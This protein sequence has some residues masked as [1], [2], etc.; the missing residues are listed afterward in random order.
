MA[1]YPRLL[2]LDYRALE[3]TAEGLENVAVLL[4]AG[5]PKAPAA[6]TPKGKWIN[7]KDIG[8]ITPGE[9]AAQ[10]AQRQLQAASCFLYAATCWAVYGR[11]ASA[12]SAYREA[13]LLYGQL[14]HPYLVVP[15]ICSNE[16][17]I[18]RVALHDAWDPARPGA[19]GAACL[20]NTIEILQG[21][22]RLTRPTVQP[23]GDL[24]RAPTH[25]RTRSDPASRRDQHHPVSRASQRD[26]PDRVFGWIHQ[27][28]L[29]A[30]A[31]ITELQA[32]K[33]H[34][35]HLA[36]PVFPSSQKQSC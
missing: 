10:S 8:W 13:A 7:A 11:A 18:T 12:R 9:T 4:A 30:D 23:R 5:P 24:L 20:A 34:W 1:Q 17:D 28:L 21:K 3:K 15:A 26:A 14:G 6:E 32:D 35:H 25:T 16:R 29:I 27:Q 22:S 2:D 31:R 33:H 36:P 19:T